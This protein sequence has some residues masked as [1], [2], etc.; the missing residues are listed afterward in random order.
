MDFI[1]AFDQSLWPKPCAKALRQS[2]EPKP[3]AIALGPRIEPMPRGI[4]LQCFEISHFLMMLFYFHIVES[5]H[6]IIPM[7]FVGFNEIAMDMIG[8]AQDFDGFLMEFNGF[9]WNS[10]DYQWICWGGQWNPLGFQSIS[11]V[12]Q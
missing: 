3:W 9:L 5:Y 2:L 4:L 10:M 8:L 7:D 1:K 6:H 12:Y 11:Y